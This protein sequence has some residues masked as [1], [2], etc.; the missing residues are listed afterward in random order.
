MAMEG[1]KPGSKQDLCWPSTHPRG[2]YRPRD[3]ER[4]GSADRPGDEGPPAHQGGDGPPYA[5]QPGTAVCL[6]RGY[7][8]D[9]SANG[10]DRG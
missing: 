10:V 3:H 1:G 6:E 8:L 5:H 7:T 2:S 4:A 9:W